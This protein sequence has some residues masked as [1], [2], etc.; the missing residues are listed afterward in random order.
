M[1]THTEFEEAKDKVMMGSERRSMAMSEEEK[2]NTA[3]HEGGHAIVAINVPES[4]PVHKATIIPRGRALGMVLQLPE[5]DRYSMKYKQMTSR[6]AIMMGGRVAEELIFGE[7][8]ITSG[9]QSDI[10]QATK[11]AR[12]MITQ[13]GYSKELGLVSYGDNQEEVFLGHS[14][15]RQQNISEDTAQIID[16]EIRRLVDEGYMTA[17]KIL[18]KKAKDLEA[19]AQGLLEFETLSGQ[20]IADLLAGKP[21]NRSDDDESGPQKAKSAVPVTKA[22]KKGDKGGGEMEPQPQA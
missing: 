19:L 21:P 8:N 22:P 15:A 18:K 13:W 14:V 2:R 9:A 7:D 1:V 4:D 5:G 16:A 6:L 3:Y 12:A 20:E 11:L 10:Q 17:K